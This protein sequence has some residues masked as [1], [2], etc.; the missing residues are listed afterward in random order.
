VANASTL[1]VDATRIAL[2]GDCAGGAIVASVTMLARERRG[3]KIDLQVLICPVI[4]ADLNTPSYERFASGPWLTR[5]AMSRAWDCWLPDVARRDQLPAA[6]LRAALH[7]LAHLPAALVI[8]AENDVARDEAECY[9]RR[10]S[11]A[12]VR[13][14]SVRYNGTIH[15]FAV[16]NALA[17]TPAARGAI[18]Q[19]TDTLR[20]TFG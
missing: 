20:Q 16:L 1:N 9:A 2:I 11:D 12:G 8:A 4:A 3:P 10:L 14:T 7:Q 6:P 13:V 5:A 18:F 15:D 17:D 19:I